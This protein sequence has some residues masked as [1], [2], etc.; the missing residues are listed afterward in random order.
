MEA[1]ENTGLPLTS[2]GDLSS[3]RYKNLFHYMGEPNLHTIQKLSFEVH[4]LRFST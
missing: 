4:L 1:N 3:A 2:V